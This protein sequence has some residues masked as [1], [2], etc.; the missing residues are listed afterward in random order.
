MRGHEKGRHCRPFHLAQADVLRPAVVVGIAAFAIDGLP[1]PASEPA[2]AR[3]EE[4]R[5]QEAEGADD[6]EDD[7]DGVEVDPVRVQCHRPGED[8][9]HGDQED[10]QSDSHA[11]GLL[12]SRKLER[13]T[14]LPGY[15]CVRVLRLLAIAPFVRKRSIIQMVLVGAAV[16]V[17]LALVAVLI[18]WLPP[19]DSA[20]ALKIDDVYW[21][22]T[23]ICIVIFALVASVSLYAV[24]KFRAAPDDTDDGAPIH[25]HTGLEVV[26]TAVPAALVTAIT[27]YSGVVLNQIDTVPKDHRVV[28]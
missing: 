16:G 12:A 27:I 20:E 9:T 22:V 24:W 26:W 5:E 19:A 7:P 13:S 10:A 8:G 6:H 23:I 28:E 2:P 18:P 21:F 25:G 17:A 14:R 3:P 1:A 15:G 11:V 4:E